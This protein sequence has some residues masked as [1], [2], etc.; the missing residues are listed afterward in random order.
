MKDK[1]TPPMYGGTDYQATWNTQRGSNTSIESKKHPY[2]K[3]DFWEDKL[4][5]F[6]EDGNYTENGKEYCR[7][8][9]LK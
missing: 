6:W 3:K 2:M 7:K 1:Y 9:L 4:I 5:H 8:A